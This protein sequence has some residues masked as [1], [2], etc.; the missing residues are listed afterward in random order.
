MGTDPTSNKYKLREWVERCKDQHGLTYDDI[1]ELGGPSSETL[2]QWGLGKIPDRPRAATLDGLD[3]ALSWEP[4][5]ARRILTEGH[6]PVP[7]GKPVGKQREQLNAVRRSRVDRVK[8]GEVMRISGTLM[9][10]LADHPT[11]MPPEV[12]LAIRE[13]HSTAMELVMEALDD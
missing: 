7:S 10:A 12:S 1:A 4:G 8:L 5:S 6:D 11:P 2:R 3:V 13:L 9:D